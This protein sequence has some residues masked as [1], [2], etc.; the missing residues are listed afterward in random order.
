MRPENEAQ[1]KTMR[2]STTIPIF[3]VITAALAACQAETENVSSR[4][5]SPRIGWTAPDPVHS[6]VNSGSVSD[7][8]SGSMVIPDE[9]TE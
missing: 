5:L 7:A 6:S 2:A 9:R 3:L 1:E 8:A 4:P